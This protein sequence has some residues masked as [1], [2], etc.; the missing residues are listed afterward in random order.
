M[1]APRRQR[2]VGRI[3]RGFAQVPGQPQAR[4]AQGAGNP[5]VVAGARRIAPQ[6]APRAR[7][8]RRW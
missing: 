7:S 6:R 2:Q 1:H 3:E 4:I 5:D 8:R